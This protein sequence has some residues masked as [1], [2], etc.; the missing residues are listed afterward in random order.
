[1]GLAGGEQVFYCVEP[2]FGYAVVGGWV[3]VAW[4]VYAGALNEFAEAGDFGADGAV[5]VFPVAKEF[6]VGKFWLFCNAV[7]EFDHVS[8]ARGVLHCD[9]CPESTGADFTLNLGDAA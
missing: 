1:L 7:N 6:F 5:D 3:F 2:E 9:A 4:D 8:A